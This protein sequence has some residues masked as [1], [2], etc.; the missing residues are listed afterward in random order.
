MDELKPCPFCGAKAEKSKNPEYII[1]I[2]HAPLCIL[3]FATLCNPFLDTDAEVIK[4]WN[5]RAE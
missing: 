1:E 4:A 2:H 5:R 3:Y